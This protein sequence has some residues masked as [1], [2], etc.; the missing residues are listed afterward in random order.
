MSKIK[1]GKH[2]RI[3]ASDLVVGI[4][5]QQSGADLDVPLGRYPVEEIGFAACLRAR[6][7]RVA[8]MFL[9]AGCL[10]EQAD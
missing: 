4:P 7:R 5:Y 3:E 10:E 6:T 2:P 9:L 1:V 8:Q